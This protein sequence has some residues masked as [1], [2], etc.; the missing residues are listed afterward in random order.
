VIDSDGEQLGVMSKIAA[1]EKARG[2]GLDLVE[3]S[4]QAKPPVVKIIDWGKYKYQQ[5]KIQQKNK[6][7]QKQ[8]ELKQ[9]RFGL[10]I[11]EHDLSVKT[12]KVADFLQDGNKVRLSVFYR[13]RELAHKELGNQLLDKIVAIL[14]ESL[15]VA[16]EQKPVFA[17]RNLSMVVR[18]K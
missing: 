7:A 17:G 15:E 5:T 12:S 6:K 11:G 13:G 1:L 10:K 14:S 16:V 9:M 2:V 3:V 8:S 4:P 18:R